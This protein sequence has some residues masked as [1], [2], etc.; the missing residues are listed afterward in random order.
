MSSLTSID[1]NLTTI[2][3][4]LTSIEGSKPQAA[5]SPNSIVETFRRSA[6]RLWYDEDGDPVPNRCVGE[7]L[8]SEA[9][10]A[11]GQLCDHFKACGDEAAAI[12]IAESFGLPVEPILR[13]WVVAEVMGMNLTKAE[14]QKLAEAAGYEPERALR[15]LAQFVR[16][17]ARAAEEDVS[18]GELARWRVLLKY[19]GVW[20]GAGKSTRAA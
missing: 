8:L 7:A 17:C 15:E 20:P 2:D 13:D 16:S 12:A 19:I 1:R 14:R 9:A 11:L 10:R 5:V 4:N 6:N 18:F 3:R